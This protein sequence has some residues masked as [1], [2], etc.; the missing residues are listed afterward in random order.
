M[1]VT[2]TVAAERRARQKRHWTDRIGLSVLSI[3]ATSCVAMLAIAL[4]YAGRTNVFEHPGHAAAAAPINLNTVAD[5]RPLEA[6]MATVFVGC[7]R[8]T[9][10]GA[11]AVPVSRRRTTEDAPAAECRRHR[12]A[13]Q[14]GGFREDEAALHRPHDRRVPA[15]S[16]AVRVHLHSGVS[17][18]HAGLA[19]ARHPD[20]SSPCRGRASAHGDRVCRPPQPRRSVARQ[21]DVRAVRRRNGCRRRRDDGRVARRLRRRRIH[22]AE[23]SAAHRRVV[24]VGA[25]D[26][27]WFGSRH[28]RREGQSGPGAAD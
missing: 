26:P 11:A 23:L 9:T 15:A 13:L 2:Y 12:A 19:V 7:E 21:P 28:Q 27:L 6:V 5:A 24:A 17:G 1:T 16:R 4:A 18:G 8:S 14:P 22:D 20:R 25:V 10:G 3:A